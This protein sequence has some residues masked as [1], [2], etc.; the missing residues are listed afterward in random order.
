[1]LCIEYLIHA[2]TLTRNKNW[3]SIPKLAKWFEIEGKSKEYVNQMEDKMG[4]TE[5]I[6]TD[7]FDHTDRK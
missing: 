3:Q 1:M 4:K 6:T 5:L 2:V 7:H